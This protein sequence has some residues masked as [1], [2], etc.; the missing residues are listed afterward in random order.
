MCQ[1]VYNES[2]DCESGV[3]TGNSIE[4]RNKKAH[5]YSVAGD[6]D[7]VIGGWWFRAVVLYTATRQEH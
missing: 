7:D 4:N 2:G 3:T 1:S 5:V 6:I